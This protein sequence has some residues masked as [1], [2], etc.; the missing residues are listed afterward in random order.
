[1]IPGTRLSILC[2]WTVPC[3]RRKVVRASILPSKMYLPGSSRLCVEI[4]IAIETSARPTIGFIR[5]GVCITTFFIENH[6]G[7]CRSHWA[8]FSKFT[9]WMHCID[10]FVSGFCVSDSVEIGSNMSV[11]WGL[12]R[13]VVEREFNEISAMRPASLTPTQLALGRVWA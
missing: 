5:T 11:N 12:K 7:L 6:S 1:M 10:P 9:E 4:E 3:H 8:T 2:P 13:D